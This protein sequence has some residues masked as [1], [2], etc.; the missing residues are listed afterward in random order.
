MTRSGPLDDVGLPREIVQLVVDQLSH[1]SSDLRLILKEV[2]SDK[3]SVVRN[4]DL[5]LLRVAATSIV[6]L[7][8]AATLAAWAPGAIASLVI[9]LYELRK[10][11]FEVSPIQ[12]AILRELK[13]HP[14]LRVNE[15][16]DGINIKGVKPRA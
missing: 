5:D 6:S 7:V 10:K 2:G 3:A 12:A 9:L 13:A 4:E 11:K 14:G 15:I 16:T 1:D 8:A